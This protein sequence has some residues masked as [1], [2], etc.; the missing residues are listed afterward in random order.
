MTSFYL[1]PNNLVIRLESNKV[2]LILGGRTQ[3]MCIPLI[4]LSQH[5]I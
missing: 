5:S 1:L 4:K 2:I 3:R